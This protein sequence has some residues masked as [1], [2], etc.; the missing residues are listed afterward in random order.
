MRWNGCDVSEHGRWRRRSGQRCG[1]RRPT[2]ARPIPSNRDRWQGRAPRRTMNLPGVAAGRSA[3]RG[4][5][6]GVRRSRRRAEMRVLLTIAWRQA[7]G[8]RSRQGQDLL[9]V[10]KVVETNP[11][12]RRP[13]P[14]QGGTDIASRAGRRIRIGDFGSASFGISGILKKPLSIRKAAFGR[15]CGMSSA[16]QF[17]LRGS[18]RGRRAGCRR[19]GSSRL[20]PGYRGGP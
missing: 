16:V 3:F 11:R 17:T 1:K 10:G 9:I 2:T 19:R 7:T 12:K 14:S 15:R 8:P 20:R 13:N 6:T 18:G 4:R 5:A